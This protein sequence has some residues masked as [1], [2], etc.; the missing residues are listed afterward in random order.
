MSF[1]I[2]PEEF[3]AALEA[4]HNLPKSVAEIMKASPELRA[5]LEP[6]PADAIAPEDKEVECM[7]HFNPK[8]QRTFKSH[9][10]WFGHG[11][12]YGNVCP[13]CDMYGRFPPE[14]IG[15]CEQPP[16]RMF[17]CSNCENQVNAGARFY[18]GLWT[19]VIQCSL[20]G[21]TGEAQ[22]KLIGRCKAC[23]KRI[24]ITLRNLERLCK[25]CR[26]EGQAQE[27][28]IGGRDGDGIE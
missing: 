7:A 27:E 1:N 5:L 16:R 9:P 11:W 23:G 21:H 25:D 18:K 6:A 13:I 14:L 15:E 24:N 19:Y 3:A 26:A 28:T 17:T 8:C 4:G 20:C 10:S 12:K 22:F 2:D